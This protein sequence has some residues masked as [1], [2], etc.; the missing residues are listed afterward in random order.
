MVR[1]AAVCLGERL[2]LIS[3]RIEL[4]G[5]RA[6]GAG[7][8]GSGVLHDDGA[9]LRLPDGRL[10]GSS[11]QLD[12]ALRNAVAF[13]A[14]SEVDAVAALTLRPAKVLGIE[15]ERGTLRPGARADFAV[16]DDAGH[17]VET[18]LAGRRVPVS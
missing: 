12:R 2:V 15:S 13:A 9:A 8:L 5:N 14:L 10:A 16:L 7:S 18:W 11:L 3:D 1:L 4:P 17:V 6:Q